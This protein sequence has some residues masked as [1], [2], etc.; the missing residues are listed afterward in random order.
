MKVSF[1]TLSCPDWSW[2]RVVSEAVRL[3]FDGIEIRGIAGE[4]LLPRIEAFL[5]ENLER[6]MEQL[7]ARKLEVCILDTSCHFHDAGGLERSLAEGREAIDLAKKMGVKYIRVFGDRIPDP[8][9]KH[10]VIENIAKGINTLCEYARG[11]NVHVLME[12]HGDFAGLDTLL[13]V[14]ERVCSPQFGILW[15]IE[16]TFKV[17]GTDVE[18]FFEK[19]WKDI[20]HVHI[21]DAVKTE[22]EFRL[23]AVGAGDVPVNKVIHLLKQVDYD[24]YLSLEWEKKWKPEL[25]EPEVAIPAYM[26]YIRSLLEA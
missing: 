18:M 2:E 23:C 26:E 8:E 3:G 21:K 4:M 11:K 20:K 10:E 13:P 25:D 12:T 7:K 9:K 6:T 5:P 24:G 17:Y 16:H 15:D 14:M 19:V 1:S 22:G